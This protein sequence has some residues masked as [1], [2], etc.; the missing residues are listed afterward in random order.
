MWLIVTLDR[1]RFFFFFLC[2]WNTGSVVC[3]AVQATEEG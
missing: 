3:K 1:M 2:V